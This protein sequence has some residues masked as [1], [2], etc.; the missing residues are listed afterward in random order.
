MQMSLFFS[1]TKYSC[2]IPWE[3]SPLGYFKK[4]KRVSCYKWTVMEKRKLFDNVIKRDKLR[5][6]MIY[7]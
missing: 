4:L 1:S 7:Y 5:F 3:I 2:K 6:A